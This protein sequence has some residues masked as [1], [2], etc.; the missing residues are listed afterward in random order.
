MNSLENQENLMTDLYNIVR[1]YD[2]KLETRVIC[3]SMSLYVAIIC[4][5]QKT[6]DD[7][8]KDMVTEY[9]INAVETITHINKLLSE[10][11]TIEE[12]YN[13]YVEKGEG[14]GK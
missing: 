12:L 8:L 11:K 2:D 10:G 9:Y 6:D 13:E 1:S 3:E 5:K 4:N 14:K 7:Q